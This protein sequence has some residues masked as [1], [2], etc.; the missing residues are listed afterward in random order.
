MVETERWTAT[1]IQNTDTD[2]LAT[3]CPSSHDSYP[4]S[5]FAILHIS[6]YSDIVK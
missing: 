5:S 3:S 2:P 4:E 1:D 6:L